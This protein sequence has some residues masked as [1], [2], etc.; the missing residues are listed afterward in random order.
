MYRLA[1]RG[2]L[3]DPERIDDLNLGLSRRTAENGSEVARLL[4]TSMGTVDWWS[5][6]EEL[7]VPTLVIHGRYDVMPVEMSQE[8]AATLPNGRLAVVE[9]GHFPFIE[10]PGGLAAAV[11]GFLTGGLR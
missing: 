1:Y 8:L 3:R 10:D 6:L 7:T 2:T 4:G 5:D 9:S 11:E